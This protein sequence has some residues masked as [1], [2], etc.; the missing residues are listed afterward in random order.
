M[1]TFPAAI[2]V[3]F[4]AAC[5]SAPQETSFTGIDTNGG[6][7]MTCVTER[8]DDLG[9]Q[10]VNQG[11]S[12]TSVRMERTNDEQFWLNLVGIEDS[13]DVID[14]SAQGPLVRLV[15]YSELV[16]GGERQSAF[17]TDQTRRAAREAV[18]KCT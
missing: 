4:L 17:P 12:E 18:E 1:R 5:A 9:Y 8:L 11:A 6:G 16:R 13:F 10:P 7:A 14:V 15:T 2:G 3:L